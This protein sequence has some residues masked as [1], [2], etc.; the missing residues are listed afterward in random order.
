MQRDVVS[1]T[2]SG[3]GCR[4]ISAAVE[5]APDNGVII[6]DRGHYT[7]NVV[8]TR[9]VTIIPADGPGSVRWTAAD[10]VPVVLAAEYAALSGL[11]I[12]AVDGYRPALLATMGT[13]SVSDCELIGSGWA[14]VVVGERGHLLMRECRVR[15]AVGD[16]VVVDVAASC[17]L[18]T[19]ELRDIGGSAIVANEAGVLEVR[20][21]VLRAVGGSGVV[22]SGQ[23]RLT[24]SNTR[25]S[26]VTGSA[27]V[28]EQQATAGLRHVA[29]TDIGDVGFLLGSTGSVSL[30]ECS[31]L[32]SAGDGVRAAGSC[33]AE[34]RECRVVAAGGHGLHLTA[35]STSRVAGCEITRSGADGILVA[36]TAQ[37]SLN[38]CRVRDGQ[39]NG[40]QFGPES[41][42]S[43][44]GSEFTGNAGDGVRIHNPDAVHVTS[45][46]LRDNRGSGLRLLPD[47]A[48][49]ADRIPR[50][51]AHSLS[52]PLRQLLGLVGLDEAKREIVSLTNLVRMAQRRDAAGLSA[53]PTARHLVF[54]GAPGTGKTTV[55]RLYGA[56]LADLGVLASGHLVEVTRIDL[57]GQTVSD[58][59]IRTTDAFTSALGGILYIDQAQSLGSEQDLDREVANT[60]AELMAEHGGDLVVIAAGPVSDMREFLAAK[61][62][63]VTRFDRTIEF[64]DY[65]PAELVTIVQFHC[66]RHDYRVDDAAG[67]ALLRY[68]GTISADRRHGNGRAAQRMFERMVDRQA[69]RLVRGNAASDDLTLLTIEDFADPA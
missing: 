54:V 18:D 38:R 10:G 4:S 36:D 53:P 59:V 3:Q 12:E 50:Q 39:S 41:S 61:R 26:R 14:T 60:L 46:V 21:C 52:D 8:L 37:A 49:S 25:I 17:V 69:S 28:I 15:N 20:S 62:G 45:C 68:F 31:V 35:R 67:A 7:E 6:L 57:V 48:A 1:V 65:T 40:C 22:A 16:G 9:A 24:A 19:C 66:Q 34:L 58:T 51:R 42:G 13:L 30:E 43:V 55:A 63:V 33:A 47:A 23:A 29:V 27:V 11:V 32:G 44:A 5:M 56:I 2:Q 64:R